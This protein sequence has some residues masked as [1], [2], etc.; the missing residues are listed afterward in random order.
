M[1][2]RTDRTDVNLQ[3]GTQAGTYQL[4]PQPAGPRPQNF[5]T[6][7]RAIPSEE[8]YATAMA[9]FEEQ[10]RTYRLAAPSKTVPWLRPACAVC[11]SL[12]W[13]FTTATSSI[14]GRKTLRCRPIFASRKATSLPATN[15]PP[16]T[17][18]LPT[19]YGRRFPQNQWRNF[20]F[21]GK[22]QNR[23]VALYGEKRAALLSASEF[24]SLQE[25]V[26]NKAGGEQSFTFNLS[27]QAEPLASVADLD[28]LLGLD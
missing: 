21:D 15:R 26:I 18:L 27:P 14:P 6:P 22:A 16:S 13:V 20:A 12:R 2:F 28:V 9:A 8:D 11:L 7:V 3:P 10:N 17:W 24:A 19:A 25:E 4:G 23:I 5:T 1:D